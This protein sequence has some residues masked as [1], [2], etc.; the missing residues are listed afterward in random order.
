MKQMKVAVLSLILL[1]VV[2]ACGGGDSP[3]A[4]AKEWLQAMAAMD[5]NKI[6][7]RTCAAQQ[8]SVQQAGLWLSVFGLF[9]QMQLGDQAQAKIDISG[10]TFTTVRSSGDT[11]AVQV[12]GRVRVAILAVSQAQDVNET[13]RMERE[14]G[15]WK[16]CGQ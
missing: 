4:A 1:C 12:S 15:K 11:A 5:G 8:A 2:S 13:W 9:G 14:D 7:E 6:A 16:W 3:E 10:L